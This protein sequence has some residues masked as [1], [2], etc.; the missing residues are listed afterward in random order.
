MIQKSTSLKYEPT[1]ELQL[2]TDRLFSDYLVVMLH[3]AGQRKLLHSCIIL[4]IVK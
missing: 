3:E 4:V 2:L 1:S